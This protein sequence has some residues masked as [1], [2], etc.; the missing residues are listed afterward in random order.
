M[1]TRRLSHLIYI[2]ISVALLA[3]LSQPSMVMAYPGEVVLVSISSSGEQGDSLSYSPSI[4]SDGRYVAFHSEAN[5]LVENDNNGEYDVFVYDR[6]FEETQRVSI[7]SSGIGG[8]RASYDP[9]ISADG[10]YVAFTSIATNLVP[11][12]TNGQ[13]DI[14]V[15]DRA[16]GQ[17]SRV[18]VSSSGQQANGPSSDPSISADGRYVAFV[19]A[20][21]N[22]ISG[23]TNG[24]DDI[25][26]Y[27][28]A[29]GQISRV[30]A[31]SS[32]QQANGPSSD[33][34]ISA[35]GRYVAF[36]SVASN[37]VSGDTN[38]NQ[39]IFVYDRNTGQID[40]IS[41]PSSGEADGPSF[42]PSISAD[43]QYVAFVSAASN[44]VSGD[45]N[46]MSDIF[47]Y[48]RDTGQISRV[49]V[50]S[51]GQQ[52]NG[53]SSAPS[54][55]A[56]GRYVAFVSAASNLVSGDDNNV[57]D[58]F[59]YDRATGQ[60]S[61]VSVSSSGQQANAPSSAPSISA[62]G[63]F[64][65]YQSRAS[66]LVS[67]DINGFQDIFVYH[68]FDNTPPAIRSI[69]AL[70]NLITSAP[71][72]SYR[73]VFSEP[74]QNVDEDDFQ[75]FTSGTISGATIASISG[76]P[77]I[78]TVRLNTGS[79]SGVLRL[80]L[81]AS[82]SIQDLAGNPISTSEF[83]G[84]QRYLVRPIGKTFISIASQD[85]WILESRENSNA[86]GS[87][88]ASASTVYIGDDA[89]N[90]Q[91]RAILS[92][93][94]RSL[95]DTAVIAKVVLKIRLQ[96]ISGTNPFSTHGSLLLDIR[97]GAFYNNP[98]LQ[99]RDFQAP[100]TW[101]AAGNFIRSGNQEYQWVWQGDGATFI[102]QASL[103][104]FRL[105]F[106]RDDD[107]DRRADIARFFSGNAGAAYRPRLIIY[108]VPFP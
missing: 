68:F 5:N 41:V 75:L 31:S 39:D 81:G 102:H 52:A 65:A 85:G 66:N 23:D 21:S 84:E 83:E 29:T 73:V 45:D 7:S 4:S 58:I 63:S 92:F 62:D 78:Y 53:P 60:I 61:R 37:L 33:P 50:S 48:A 56:D 67:N 44:L 18:S 64:I 55:S 34:S 54:I 80:D 46:N 97:K 8:N 70:D 10:R 69:A 99:M 35:D 74:V 9:S 36:A 72:V 57:S 51:S 42:A 94:T 27:D 43:G 25:F 86:G 49:S 1:Y 93:D 106:K 108:Y 2:I 79:G 91:Y 103:T 38:L 87:M 77:A 105:R 3:L 98:A 47:V 32:G 26:V 6:L 95:P 107:N 40:R 20:A 11:G 15:Y 100:A 96:G 30:S 89:G 104:Q 12:D 16:T 22:L 17:I 101:S 76:G 82:P 14:F 28:R 19:S 88:N 59:V 24:E 71:S 90:R 13:D